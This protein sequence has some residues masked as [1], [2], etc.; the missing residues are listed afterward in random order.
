[1]TLEARVDAVT[2]RLRITD[3]S[4]RPAAA[5]LAEQ[6]PWAR[7]KRR[8]GHLT[9]SV[10]EVLKL[11]RGGVAVGL[12]EDTAR[13]LANREHV[14]EFAAPVLETSRRILNSG[15]SAARELLGDCSISDKLDDHQA[16]N[17]AAMVVPDGW[18]T[19]VFDEQGTGKT[20][21]VVGAF[22][23][24]VSRQEAETLLVVAPKSMI[25]EW[26]VEFRRFAGGLY[27]VAVADGTRVQ[28]A[29]AIN[30]G[31]DVV[32]VN[33]ETVGRLAE[34]LKLLAKRSR[35]VMAI[36]E[37]FFVKN[38]DSR[39]AQAV[40][41]LREWCTRCYVLCGTPAP[42]TAHDLVAQVDLVDF[43]HTFGTVTIDKDRQIAHSQVR[44]VLDERGFYLRNLKSD[45]LPYLPQ[46]RFIEVPVEMSDVQR[47]VYDRLHD[48]LVLEL[49]A[50]SDESF[51]RQVVHFLE[52]RALLLRICSDP[53]P[54]LE[55]YRETPVKVAALDS[56]LRDLIEVRG[57]KVVVWSFYRSS[58]DRIVER[59][60]RLGVARIDGS[61]TSSAERRDAV[62]RFQDDDETMLFVGNPAAAGAG[63]TLHRSRFA[64]YESFS[65]QAAHYLQSLD[66]IHRRGQ[67]REVE[68]MHLLTTDSL[69]RAEYRR[70]LD[71]ADTQADLLG[72]GGPDRV[73]RAILLEEL[74]SSRTMSGNTA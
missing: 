20:I 69:E 6:A 67:G 65:N 12:D 60:E 33:Y 9:L 36:D 13:W 74:L 24:L 52:R 70:L 71:K 21:S 48:D 17:V 32:V 2:G 72:D 59:Y 50:T 4:G 47:S 49:Q 10:D 11:Q 64:I 55:G 7:P 18:G 58:L 23:A 16:V 62:K 31:A 8:E 54:V 46:R 45:V 30:S 53:T 15:A 41:D 34:V 19:C 25:G 29:R 28:R 63:L 14:R 5:T 66:R 38:P 3:H 35:T 37:S 68:Y 26:A 40:R 73:T 56:L 61:V 27:D 44:S 39:R 22:D 57:E 42:N 43:G 51:T 1:M